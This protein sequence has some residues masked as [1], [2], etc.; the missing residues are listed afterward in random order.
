MDMQPKISARFLP[1]AV[2]ALAGGFATAA[3]A[4]AQ[5]PRVV[6]GA[7]PAVVPL[8]GVESVDP[9]DS[10]TN[11]RAR[12]GMNRDRFDPDDDR[13]ERETQ[14]SK[15]RGIHGRETSL[16]CESSNG[17]Y[18]LCQ[19]AV[20]GHVRLLREL[21]RSD[22][23]AGRTWGWSNGGI[24]VDKGCRAEFAYIAQDARGAYGRGRDWRDGDE[25]VR[26]S[27]RCESSSGRS[28]FCAAPI[29]G[30]VR[31]TK[32]L[33]RAP[34]RYGDTWKFDRKGISVRD[35]CRAEF[36]FDARAW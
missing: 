22:C 18:K 26:G 10:A 1:L 20:S 28:N 32:Q 8:A 21:S 35:G 7:A 5:P 11:D 4:A 34:C 12:S 19:A 3:G 36:S 33:S 13:Y 15:V 31:M 24:W 30:D 16:R 23:A 29:I 2:L 14:G 27:L 6:P 17:R 9:R 25:I